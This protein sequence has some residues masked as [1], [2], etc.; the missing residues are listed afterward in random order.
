MANYQPPKKV[1]L[2]DIRAAIESHLWDHLMDPHAAD[3][4]K[5]VRSWVVDG[6]PAVLILNGHFLEV[7]EERGSKHIFAKWKFLTADGANKFGEMMLPYATVI[8]LI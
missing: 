5:D 4:A 1:E 7:I 6:C 2:P 3:A 8:G